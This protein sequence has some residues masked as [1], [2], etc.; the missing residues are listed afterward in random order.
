MQYTSQKEICHP[1]VQFNVWCIVTNLLHRVQAITNFKPDLHK[2]AQ[3]I[4]KM[5]LLNVKWFIQSETSTVQ[6]THV[7]LNFNGATVEI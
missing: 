1:I 2:T 3:S 6:I 7:F 4:A 5:G